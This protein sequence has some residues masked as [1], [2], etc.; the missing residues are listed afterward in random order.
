MR[1]LRAMFVCALLLPMLANAFHPEGPH[2]GIG[3]VWLKRSTFATV[4]TW[5]TPGRPAAAQ[6]ESKGPVAIK[7]MPIDRE[8]AE[9]VAARGA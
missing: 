2:A 3:A 1:V 5:P 8:Q 9:A 6:G 7:G 4:T